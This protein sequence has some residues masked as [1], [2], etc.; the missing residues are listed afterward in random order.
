MTE[1]MLENLEEQVAQRHRNIRFDIH[2]IITRMANEILQRV[3]FESNDVKAVKAVQ[4]AASDFEWEWPIPMVKSTEG[5]N[6]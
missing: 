6:E 5:N 1:Q 4:D 2:S 3:M